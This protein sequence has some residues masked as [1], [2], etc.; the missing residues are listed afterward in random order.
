MK[1]AAARGVLT[2]LVA[3]LVQN[4]IEYVADSRERRVVVRER[5]ADGQDILVGRERALKPETA[6]KSRSTRR[7][8]MDN[9]HDSVGGFHNG[10]PGLADTNERFAQTI[11]GHVSSQPV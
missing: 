1:C 2:S 8:L 7:P 10:S 3:N 9:E 6:A 11:G 4:A 5:E